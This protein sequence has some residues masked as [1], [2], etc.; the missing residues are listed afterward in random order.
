M[1]YGSQCGFLESQRC[2]MACNQFQTDRWYAIINKYKRN[3]QGDKYFFIALYVSRFIKTK[4]SL[5]DESPHSD[6]DGS[7]H[8]NHLKQ[9]FP[10]SCFYTKRLSRSLSWAS[11]RK[12]HPTAGQ[13]PTPPSWTVASDSCP[14]SALENFCELGGV[15][16]QNHAPYTKLSETEEQNKDYLL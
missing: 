6:I 13:T 8:S 15:S 12:S 16:N 14:G 4:F 7:A 5:S 3:Q 2:E 10:T 11:H 1:D 9:P